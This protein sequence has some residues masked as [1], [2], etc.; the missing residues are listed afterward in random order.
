MSRN[1]QRV[2]LSNQFLSN[3]KRE[4]ATIL[5]PELNKTHIKGTYGE[6]GLKILSHKAG[7]KAELL[8]SC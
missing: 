3:E 1:L 6:Q 7:F 2:K 4:N 8:I 5:M